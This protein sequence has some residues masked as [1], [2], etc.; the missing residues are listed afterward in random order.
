MVRSLVDNVKIF[1]GNVKI[2]V[3]IVVKPAIPATSVTP[4]PPDETRTRKRQRSVG[5]VSTLSAERALVGRVSGDN[6]MVD[7][8]CSAPAI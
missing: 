3:N 1:V 7:N 2:N 5:S 6:G 8:V 4:R